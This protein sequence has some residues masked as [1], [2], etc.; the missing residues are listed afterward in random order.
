[1]T[2]P[3]FTDETLMAF[4]DGELDD[5]MAERVAAAV[6]SDPSV[7]RRIQAFRE[8]RAALHGALEPLGARPVPPALRAAIEARVAQ[9]RAERGGGTVVSLPHPRAGRPF[10]RWALPLAASVALAVGSVGGYVAGQRDA[11]PP[12]VSLAV[13]G[14]LA[15]AIGRATTG[16]IETLGD[17][18]VVRMVATFADGTGALCREFTQVRGRTELIAIACHERAGWQLRFAVHSPAAD[19]YAPAS[20]PEALE[21]YLQDIEA[22]APLVGEAERAALDRLH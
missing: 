1:M 18:A 4:A 16:E 11:G 5:A 17:G 9:T 21:V 15:A 3:D 14:D 8:T 10:T 13:G 7:A 19:G 6:A 20:V 12:A 2:A 22:G